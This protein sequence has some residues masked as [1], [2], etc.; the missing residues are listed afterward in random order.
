[1]SGSSFNAESGAFSVPG[2]TTA[3]FVGF[4]SVGAPEESRPAET[5]QEITTTPEPELPE[6]DV[7]PWMWVVGIIGLGGLIGAGVYALGRR[8]A[9]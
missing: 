6:G 9:N 5:V 4:G 1:V 8:R 7:S 2:R 3:V